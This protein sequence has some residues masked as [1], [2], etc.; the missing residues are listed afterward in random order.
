MSS[1]SHESIPHYISLS[2]TVKGWGTDKNC[3]NVQVQD[4]LQHVVVCEARATIGSSGSVPAPSRHSSTCSPRGHHPA[5]AMCASV[6]DL[7]F[8]AESMIPSNELWPLNIVADACSGVR[9]S[10]RPIFLLSLFKPYLGLNSQLA[11]TSPPHRT[12]SNPLMEFKDH[13]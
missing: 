8:L 12:N 10:P 7:E 11:F 2:D 6:H 9:R 13:V 5:N 1:L 3:S 4:V